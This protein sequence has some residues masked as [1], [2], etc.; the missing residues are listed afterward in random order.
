MTSTNQAKYK[1]VQTGNETQQSQSNSSF[2]DQ[3]PKS[4][5]TSGMKSILSRL[6]KHFYKK[7]MNPTGMN[8][9]ATSL[10]NLIS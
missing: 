2:N 5:Q 6:N 7:K 9:K 1:I 3:L 4:K 10:Y 8:I